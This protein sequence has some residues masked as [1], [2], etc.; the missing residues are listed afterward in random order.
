MVVSMLTLSVAIPFAFLSTSSFDPNDDAL[1]GGGVLA[2]V[3]W[4]ESRGAFYV[5]HW[6]DCI[7]L[8]LCILC[9]GWTLFVSSNQCSGLTLYLPDAESKLEMIKSVATSFGDLWF[10]QF[11]AIL[12]LLLSLPFLAARV[13]PPATICAVLPF[14][15]VLKAFLGQFKRRGRPG[16][17]HAY[18][19]LQQ[20]IARRI[21]AGCGELNQAD[22]MDAATPKGAVEDDRHTPAVPPR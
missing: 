22:A 11:F 3:G 4:S 19:V 18:G 20:Q 7:C 21:I 15:G 6:I 17:A 9:D 2:F 16:N 13:S 14:V 1:G 5:L 8:S 12:F 10:G